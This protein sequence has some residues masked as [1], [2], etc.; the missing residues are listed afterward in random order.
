MNLVKSSS[1][2]SS[3]AARGPETALLGCEDRQLAAT[4][5]SRRG[6]GIAAVAMV[7]MAVGGGVVATA[8]EA[9]LNEQ[10]D[11]LLDTFEQRAIVAKQRL[12][13]A[14]QQLRD[15]QGRVSV[16]I[17]PPEAARTCRSR[18]LKRRWR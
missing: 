17:E 12:A 15:V 16:G 9:R 6:A 8:Y 2:T 10:R 13:L 5:E 1:T 3:S 11:I 7:S 4:V 18:S 14:M